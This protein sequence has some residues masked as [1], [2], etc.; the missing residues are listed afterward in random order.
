MT[1]VEIMREIFPL[2]IVAAVFIGLA[3]GSWITK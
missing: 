3:V 1:P 2:L